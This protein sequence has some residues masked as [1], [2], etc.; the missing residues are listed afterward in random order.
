MND[1]LLLFKQNINNKVIMFHLT[2]AMILMTITLAKK[3]N[4]TDFALL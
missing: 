1:K 2:F 3:Y 4:E